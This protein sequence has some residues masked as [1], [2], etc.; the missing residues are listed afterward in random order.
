M[1]IE[2]ELKQNLVNYETNT[3]LICFNEEIISK[4][5]MEEGTEPGTEPKT[6]YLYNCARVKKGAGYGDIVT[7]IIRSRYTADQ[8]EAIVLNGADTPEHE[9]ELEA[10]QQWRTEAKRIAKQVLGQK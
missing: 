6:M 8:V 10:L 2:F 1:K 5:V 3:N 4:P 9:A 7:A